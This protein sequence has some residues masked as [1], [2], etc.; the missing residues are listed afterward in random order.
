MVEIQST[1]PVHA[2]TKRLQ[3]DHRNGDCGNLVEVDHK[4]GD[5]RNLPSK[6]QH[7]HPFDLTRTASEL[8]QP[9]FTSLGPNVVGR[10]NPQSLNHTHKRS[11]GSFGSKALEECLLNLTRNDDASEWVPPL[12]MAQPNA[13][14][15]RASCSLRVLSLLR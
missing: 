8:T 12:Q 7:F 1:S 5:C 10:A 2:H 9:S 4:T 6:L 13:A 15:S 14:T 3:S 11:K